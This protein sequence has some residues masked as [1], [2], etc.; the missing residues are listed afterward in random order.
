V[1]VPS[2]EAADG[3]AGAADEDGKADA[4]AVGLGDGPSAP[5]HA[6][7]ARTALRARAASDPGDAERTRYKETAST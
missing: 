5:P 2:S 3:D 1:S 6:A 7:T 4:G